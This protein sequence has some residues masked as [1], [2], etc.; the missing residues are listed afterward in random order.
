MT[1]RHGTTD[2]EAAQRKRAEALSRME[3]AIEA[4]TTSDGFRDWLRTAAKFHHYSFG[5]QLLIAVQRPDA[6]RVAGFRAWLELGRHVRKGSHGIQIIVPFGARKRAESD[7]DDDEDGADSDRRRS[8]IGFGVGYVFDVSDTDG[9]ELPTLGYAHTEGETAGELWQRIQAVAAEL[10]TPIRSDERQ[11]SA[12]GY[13]DP[14]KGEIWHRPD[15]STDGR[16]S[17]VLHELAHVLDWRA[18]AAAGDPF[19]YRDHRGERETVAEAVA[20]VAAD[21]FEL[22]TGAETFTYVASWAHDVK[23]LKARMGEIQRLADALI[24]ALE[25]ADVA[26]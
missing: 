2:P 26:A 22:D 18:H 17:T 25:G 21:H 4:V 11:T 20:Y 23:V 14:H 19:D 9:D 3:A 8:S 6:T 12:T 10:G 5:N 24:T 16:A 1:K 13:F 15:L 7:D